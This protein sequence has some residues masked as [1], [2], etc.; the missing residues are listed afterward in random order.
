MNLFKKLS[1]NLTL[2]LL[3]SIGLTSQ[4]ISPSN[5]QTTNGLIDVEIN[6]QSIATSKQAKKTLEAHRLELNKN[7]SRWNGKKISNIYQFTLTRTCFCTPETTQPVRI[8]VSNGKL[9][10]LVAASN[11]SPVKP[12]SFKNYTTVPKLFAVIDNA[13]QKK[14]ANI[15]VKYHPKF[16]YP[17]EINIDYD[18]RLA[19]EELSLRVDN[20]FFAS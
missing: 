15:S 20:L 17:T 3:L 5:A 14:A 18:L 4:L 1:R 16:G 11:G 8:F 7:I 9:I 19:D 12:E 13:I 6:S 2:G 10:S